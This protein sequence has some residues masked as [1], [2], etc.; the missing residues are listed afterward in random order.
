MIHN[1]QSIRYERRTLSKINENPIKHK[2][3]HQQL[4]ITFWKVNTE[5]LLGVEFM[6]INYLTTLFPLF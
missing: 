3:S 6:K 5:Q 4:Y 2:L 1:F